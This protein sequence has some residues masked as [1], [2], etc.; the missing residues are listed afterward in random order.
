M[1]KTARK[2]VRKLKRTT[3][4]IDPDL[5]ANVRIQA[6]RESRPAVRVLEEALRAYLKKKGVKLDG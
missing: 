1:S 3:V 4:I 2:G 5:W 6:M